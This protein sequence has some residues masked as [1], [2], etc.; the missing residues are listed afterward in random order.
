MKYNFNSIDEL[1]DYMIHQDLVCDDLIELKE[2]ILDDEYESNKIS[3]LL[4]SLSKDEALC[5]I[6][7]DNYK[8]KSD[9]EN[10]RNILYAIGL[11]RNVLNSIMRKMRLSITDREEDGD[12]NTDEEYSIKPT[13]LITLNYDTAWRDRIFKFYFTPKSNGELTIEKIIELAGK[14][15]QDKKVLDIIVNYYSESKEYFEDS[16]W[17]IAEEIMRNYNCIPALKNSNCKTLSKQ[18]GDAILD[19][20]TVAQTNIK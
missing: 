5:H 13:H 11:K 6:L 12:K 2:Q 1:R 19:A 18:I 7:K 9:I 8:N 20:F 4:S 15:Y 16:V 17:G 10:M 14:I 3:L